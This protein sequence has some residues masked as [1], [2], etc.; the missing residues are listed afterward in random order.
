MTPTTHPNITIA[1]PVEDY[2]KIAFCHI[3]DAKEHL[4]AGQY[5]E[6]LDRMCCAVSHFQ[7]VKE[8]FA[9]YGVTP[10]VSMK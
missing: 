2:F 10:K 3:E 7:N 8:S 1:V 9:L 6:F 4:E 5:Q